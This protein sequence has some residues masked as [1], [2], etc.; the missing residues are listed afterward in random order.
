MKNKL[1]EKAKSQQQLKLIYALRD[2]YKTRKN[3]PEEDKWVFDKEWTEGVKM[4][5]LPKKVK[6]VKEFNSF[7]NEY[8]D[9]A[10]YQRQE[11]EE[12]QWYTKLK[13]LFDEYKETVGMKDVDLIK[14]WL[15]EKDEDVGFAEEIY[16]MITK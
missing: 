4:K 11:S 12:G 1:D 7:V 10:S 15:I 6:H 9:E 5:K 13:E 3:A 2:K 14:Q 8:Y 16:K